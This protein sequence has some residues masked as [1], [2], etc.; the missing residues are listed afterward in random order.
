MVFIVEK[1]ANEHVA[2]K[3]IER[4]RNRCV[5][6]EEVPR[7]GRPRDDL[8]EGLRTVPF[9]HSAVIAYIIDNDVVKITNVFYGGQDF[10]ALYAGYS[11][12]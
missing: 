9:E 6:I 2:D 10:E 1:S 3:F 5:R 7:Q 11:V 12:S 8:F 4:I